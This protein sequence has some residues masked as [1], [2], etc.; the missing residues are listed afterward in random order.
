MQTTNLLYGNCCVLSPEGIL[1][2][3][4]NEKKINWYLKRDLA[5]IVSDNPKT[6][7][8]KFKPNGLGNHNKPYGLTEMHNRCVNCG[9]EEDLTKH[10]VIPICYRKHF[11]IELKSHNF[12]D[13]LPMCISCHE[14]YERKADILKKE[15]SLKYNAPLSGILEGEEQPHYK[16]SKLAKTLLNNKTLPDKKVKSLKNFIK[17]ELLIKRL[18]NKKLKTLSEIKPSIH[19]VT[20]GE[21]VMSQIIDIHSFIEMW[22]KHFIENNECNFLPQNWHITYGIK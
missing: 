19:R 6:I 21:I 14:K 20:H 7:Q 9:I 13:V 10:H 8:L 3:R 12:H 2:F 1:M 18:T 11:S 17:R 16:C 22:R 5:D 4:C 15:L